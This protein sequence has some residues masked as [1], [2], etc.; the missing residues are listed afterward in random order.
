MVDGYDRGGPD[1][2]RWWGWAVAALLILLLGGVGVLVSGAL[3]ADDRT[4]AAVGG[5]PPSTTTVPDPPPP[6]VPAPPSPPT[7]PAPSPTTTPVDGDTLGAEDR[8]SLDGIGPVRV[9][10]TLAEASAAA[11]QGISEVPGS[12]AGTDPAAC[13]SAV[14]DTG[15]PKVSF[16]VVGGAIARVDVGEGSATRTIS[17]IGVGAP[18]ADVLAT[19][20]DRIVVEPHPSIEGGHH[21][22]YVPDD[23]A[24]SLIFETDGATVRRYRSGEADAVLAAEGCA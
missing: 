13:F 18:E 6:S 10:M 19:Y 2:R 24:R 14:P 4:L 23:P 22:R 20:G 1:H 9:G 5:P 12:G 17:G 16:L 7:T 11:G 8:I 3:R 21:L 15:Q